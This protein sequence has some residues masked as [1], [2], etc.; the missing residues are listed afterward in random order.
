VSSSIYFRDDYTLAGRP[1]I[2]LHHCNDAKEVNMAWYRKIDVRIWGDEK[3]RELS[4]MEPSGQALWI[5]LL[6]NPESHSIPGLFRSGEAS[7]AE[8]LCWDLKDFRKAFAE[9]FA[10]GLAEADWNARVVW[11]P[12]AIKYN[13]PENPNVV[14]SWAA[15]WDVIPECYLKQKAL[16]QAVL[17]M[18]DF[19]EGFRKAFAEAF[20]EPLSKGL[21][22]QI[23]NNKQQITNNKGI[24]VALEDDPDVAQALQASDKKRTKSS[25]VDAV[26]AA[27]AKHHPRS[28]P[29]AKERKLIVD[30]LNESHDVETLI[31]AIDGCHI[32][33]HN[34]GDNERHQK[35]QTLELIMRTSSN[36]TRFAETWID[37]QSSLFSNKNEKWSSIASVHGCKLNEQEAEA[38]AKSVNYERVA[39]CDKL[40]EVS[41]G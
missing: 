12:N 22:N 40:A 10:K 30:R 9:V 33:P 13:R 29:G 35:Y 6:T 14:K 34:C 17:R 36:V 21:P 27:Y 5:Y 16:F 7:I 19:T 26:V 20:A 2:I 31:A 41:N 38:I 8:S 23:T 3:F 39:F 24:Y 25:D 11:I 28:R 18:E 4:R 1:S 15:H 32:T 37:R